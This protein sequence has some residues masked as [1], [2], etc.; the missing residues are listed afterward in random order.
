MMWWPWV[1]A[2]CSSAAAIAPDAG[3]SDA[4][5]DVWP[6]DGGF[7][8]CR[9]SAP[10][11]PSVCDRFG[12]A[13]CANWALESVEGSDLE[14]YAQCVWRSSGGSSTCVAADRELIDGGAACGSGS[15]C[16]DHFACGRSPTETEPRCVAC[17]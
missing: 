7:H 8:G 4:A 10:P 2:G 14:A 17:D 15:A 1:V 11:S 6:I 3:P 5:V 16:A 13:A 12:Q 9:A